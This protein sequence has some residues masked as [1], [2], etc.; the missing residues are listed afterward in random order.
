MKVISQPGR[1]VVMTLAAE[2][3]GTCAASLSTS[4]ESGAVASTFAKQFPYVGRQPM[5][6]LMR[7]DQTSIQFPCGRDQ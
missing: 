7:L 1:L 4:E 5:T 3:V 2:G 6:R